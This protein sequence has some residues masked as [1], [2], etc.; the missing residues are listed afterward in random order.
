LPPEQATLVSA[1]SGVRAPGAARFISFQVLSSFTEKGAVCH[2]F[3][4]GQAEK[5]G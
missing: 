4:Q 2:Q 3:I 1:V 5:S